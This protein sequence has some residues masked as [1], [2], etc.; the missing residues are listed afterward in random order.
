MKL[1]RTCEAVG[2]HPHFSGYL[3]DYCLICG[4]RNVTRRLPNCM[5]YE[6]LFHAIERLIPD[7]PR[8]VGEQVCPVS[9]RVL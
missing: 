8:G 3:I 5:K 4:E 9:G 2:I 6:V 1:L 7:D